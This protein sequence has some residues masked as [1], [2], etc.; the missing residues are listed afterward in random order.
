[1]TLW[2]LYVLSSFL[3]SFNLAK[4]VKSKVRS[5]FVLLFFI[6]LITPSQ[7]EVNGSSLGPSI[8]IFL[9]DL[10]FEQYFSLRSLRPL[11]LTI[12][13]SFFLLLLGYFI[14]KRFFQNS[15]R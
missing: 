7:I 2:L 5:Q 15:N 1:M 11:A 10:I 8:F 6:L 13:F 4:L 12:P 3:I 9:Y 14:K